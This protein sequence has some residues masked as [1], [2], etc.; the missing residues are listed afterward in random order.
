[1]NEQEQAAF[2]GLHTAA[3]IADT[4]AYALVPDNHQW[5]ITSD[6]DPSVTTIV[7]DVLQSNKPEAGVMEEAPVAYEDII[8]GVLDA[9]IKA[10]QDQAAQDAKVRQAL[11]QLVK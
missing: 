1:M 8:R 11:S 7:A 10:R 3:P 6:P 2:Y 5:F 9:N 4:E